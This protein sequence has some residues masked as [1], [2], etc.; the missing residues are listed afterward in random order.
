MRKDTEMS[1]EERLLRAIVGERKGPGQRPVDP[2]K[3]ELLKKA[4]SQS[5]EGLDERER[6]VVEMRFGLG[7]GYSKTLEE[8]GKQFKVTRERIRQIETKAI[9]KMRHPTRVKH[10]KGLLES[11]GGTS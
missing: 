8:V 1:Q 3:F 10:L 7:D 9:R 11:G 2:E 5:T 4:L 6:K